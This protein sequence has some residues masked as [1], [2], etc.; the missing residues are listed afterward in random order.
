[1]GSP[2]FCLIILQSAIDEKKL[3]LPVEFVSQ[4]G[5]D[6]SKFATFR[7]PDGRTWPILTARRSGD[8]KKL[9][10]RGW[11]EFAAYYSI[12]HAYLI[13]F[14]YKGNS[15][16]HVRIFDPTCCE[17]V[18]PTPRTGD[19]HASEQYE[20]D[21]ES[22]GGDGIPIT[23]SR[24]YDKV[25]QKAT[26]SGQRTILA[27]K[28]RKL[29]NPSFMLVVQP[30]NLSNPVAYVPGEFAAKHLSP[31]C[32][33]ILVRDS[34]SRG[35][36][37]IQFTWRDRGGLNLGLGWGAFTMDNELKPEDVCR[38]ELISSDAERYCVMKAHLFRV[39]Y[40]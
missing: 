6:L 29:H 38:F 21:E 23:T 33:S 37:A 30:Y 32:S 40:P 14:K 35:E 22:S 34:V 12:S 28:K 19:Q 9:F 17:I 13:A 8:G 36:W 27:A 25:Y 18:Y 10:T 24:N 16:F 2:S 15:D 4:H 31:D 7:A 26:P 11:S 3:L 5:G 20:N 1:M 39:S